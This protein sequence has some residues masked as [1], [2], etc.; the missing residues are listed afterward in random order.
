MY[1]HGVSKVNFTLQD[2]F[3]SIGSVIMIHVFYLVKKPE[4]V[5]YYSS[6]WITHS[7][8]QTR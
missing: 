2:K 3:I 5:P 1:A 8:R 4:Q 7:T 6:T